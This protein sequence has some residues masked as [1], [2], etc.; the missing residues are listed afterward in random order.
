M[1]LRGNSGGVPTFLRLMRDGPERYYKPLTSTINRTLED[2]P[3]FTT[4]AGPSPQLREAL[5]NGFRD[6]FV[7]A[8]NFYN[9][10][11]HSANT[12]LLITQNLYVLGILSDILENIHAITTSEN[13]FLLSDA[14]ELLWLIIKDDQ[15]PFIYEKAGNVF[16]HFMIDEFQDTSLIQWNN[17]RPLIENSLAQGFDN[18]VVGDIKQSIYRWRNSDWKILGR[19]L[20]EQFGKNRMTTE[21]LETNWRSK[22]NIIAFNNSLFSVLPALVDNSEKNTTGNFLLGDLY[23]D[24]IQKCPDNREGGYVN[25]SFIDDPESDFEDTV[26]GKLPGL[27]EELQDKGFSG[28]D[29]GILVRTNSEGSEVLRYLLDY[30]AEAGEEKR[31]KYNYN[32]ISNESLL[33]SLSPA[34]E[35]IVSL[36]SGIYDPADNLSRAIMARNWLLSAGNDP[37]LADLSDTSSIDKIL[38]EGFQTFI[39]GIKQMPLFEAVEQII[40]FFGIGEF[41]ENTAYLN[42]FQDCVLEFSRDNS[43]DISSF[44]EWW[45][46]SGIKRSIVLSDKQDS[47]RVMTIHKSKG[48]EFRVVLVPFISWNLGHGRFPPTLW[49][50]PQKAP[51]SKLGL[52][53]VKYR[54]DL[55]YSDF[56]DDYFSESFFALVDNVNMLYVAFTRAV[57]CL[58][59]FAPARAAAGSL[60]TLL[61]ESL[62]QASPACP[63]KPAAGLNGNFDKVENVYRLGEIPKIESAHDKQG[64]T[65]IESGPYFVNSRYSRL[66]LKFHGQSWLIKPDGDQRSKLNYGRVMH[67]IFESIITAD[68]IPSAVNKK[69]LEGMI[70]VSAREEMEDRLRTAISR[71]EISGWFT[72]GLKILNEAEILTEGGTVKRPDRVILEDDRVIVVDFKFGAERKSYTSQVNNYKNLLLNMGYAKVDGYLWYVDNDKVIRI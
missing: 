68:D 38:P 29:I 69:I 34:V 46:E 2:P 27:I 52:V 43:S 25:I 20:Q 1:F 30:S 51:F 63:D 71:P 35:F 67:E 49:L 53:P 33:I 44:L 59:G 58:I 36:L 23:S 3:V 5:D 39:K 56:A 41:P 64:E 50:K 66:H 54:A 24:V 12:S 11:F 19:I 21:Y 65:R 16:E 9:N 8:V 61:M 17:F 28:G 72:A 40:L 62:Q 55:Q 32:I 10:N 31:R 60:S 7:E 4:K 14:G 57:D 48:L 47:M 45:E 13:R 70:P 37:L 18:L 26:L 42:A 6:I 15:T 22:M